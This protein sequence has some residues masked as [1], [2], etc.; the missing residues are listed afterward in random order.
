MHA[1]VIDRVVGDPAVLA[2]RAAT[3]LGV[4]A[5]DVRASLQV[6]GGGPAIIAVH[7]DAADATTTASALAQAGFAVETIDV[8]AQRHVPGGFVGRWFEF[9]EHALALDT[10]DARRA[11]VP[12][13]SVDLVLLV[14]AITTDERNEV[15]REKVFSP[16]RALLSGGLVNTRTR[17]TAQRSTSMDSEEIAFVF[18]ADGV[19]RLA[20]K[21]L[22]YQGLAG[23]LQPA[24][25][26]N[27]QYLVAELRRRC[28]Q[29]IFDDRLRK[30][31]LQAQVLGRVLSPDDYLEL[32]V[33]MFATS[34]R[35]P[36]A[37][38]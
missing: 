8:E 27:F 3:A 5:F 28:P 36:R 37:Q 38:P 9:G 29:A 16:G 11:A 23:A 30:R 18:A 13:A 14:M 1:V 25:T 32:A 6:P 12:Y 31:S 26:A 34:L 17:E 10:R 15:V 19:F 24:R 2:Q 7:A 35:R 4:T 33:T 22:V 21:S 20:E